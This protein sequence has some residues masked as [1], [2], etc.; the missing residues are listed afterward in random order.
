MSSAADVAQL[1]YLT[2]TEAAELIRS[3]QLSP[4]DLTEAT[5]A[6][7]DALDP[8]L[9]SYALV[10]SELALETARVA[11]REIVHGLYRGPLHGIPFAVKDLCYTEGIITAAGT[12]VL[13]DFVPSFDSTVVNRLKASGGILTGKLRMTEGAYADHHPELP[14]PV[15]PW[16]PDVWVGSSSSGPGVATAAGLCFASL[17]SDTGG[18]IRLP[19]SLNGLTGLKPTWGRVSRYGVVDLAPSYDHIGPMTRSAADN[20]V[21]LR[22]IAGADQ[23]DPT[24]LLAPVPDYLAM[25]DE[26]VRP[27][28]GFDPAFVKGFDPEVR[29]M[30]ESVLRV[31]ESLGWQIVEVHVPEVSTIV[32]YSVVL[33]AVEAAHAHA[34]T[35]PSRASEYGPGLR[36]LLE[37][38][39]TIKA[40]DYHLRQKE[41]KDFAGRMHRFFEN[42]DILVIPGIGVAAPTN[43]DMKTLGTDTRLLEAL[44]KPTAPFDISG[45]PTI[46]VPAGLSSRGTPMGVQFASGALREDL[47]LQVAHAFQTATDF[48]L[49][50]PRF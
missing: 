43:D 16:D 38:G 15:N 39:L 49:A 11:E 37:M 13:K 25:I 36:S 6:R 41:A 40:T 8:T 19:S 33:S 3:R 22:A 12:T 1:S 44:L 2:L 45:T 26:P 27:R 35:F 29:E 50:H 32:E 47:L 14:T 5:L 42:V 23:H 7:I 21:V 48:H 20:A 46:T 30:L 31:L 18:S 28:V 9:S 24:A 34:Q 10:T 4:V 17:G